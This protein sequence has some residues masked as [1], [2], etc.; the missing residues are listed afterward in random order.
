MNILQIAA[1]GIQADHGSWITYAEQ[2]SYYIKE[3]MIFF[4]KTGLNNYT[5]EILRDV[6]VWNIYNE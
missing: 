6:C 5:S 3:M 1:L 4:Q 2:R